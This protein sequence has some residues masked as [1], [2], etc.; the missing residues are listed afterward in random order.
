MSVSLCSDRLAAFIP[1]Y[2]R[3]TRLVAAVD[4]RVRDLLPFG[5]GEKVLRVDVRV[6][7]EEWVLHHG[8]E[9]GRREGG[10]DNIVHATVVNLDVLDVKEIALV[11]R[12]EIC[13]PILLA[14]ECLEDA[15]N[16]GF[17]VSDVNRTSSRCDPY[18]VI[19]ALRPVERKL[20]HVEPFCVLLAGTQ[21][22]RLSHTL[23]CRFLRGTH[24]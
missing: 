10:V 15:P 13:L 16:P 22:D 17:G 3:G 21:A 2:V 14:R 8:D 20:A 19:V 18:L 1:S 23:E 24:C 11:S 4:L 7:K 12:R 6:T 5:Q 9:F